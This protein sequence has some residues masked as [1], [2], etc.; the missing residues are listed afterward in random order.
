M[1]QIRIAANAARQFVGQSIY[2]DDTLGYSSFC[3]CE[4]QRAIKKNV[5]VITDGRIYR[6]LR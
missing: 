4:R 6:V 1:L 5:V 2:D 3:S